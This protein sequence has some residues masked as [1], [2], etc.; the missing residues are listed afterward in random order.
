MPKLGQIKKA[1]DW[2]FEKDLAAADEWM[3]A[4]HDEI[5]LPIPDGVTEE[6]LKQKGEELGFTIQ[7]DS[8]HFNV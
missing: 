7:E 6:E 3:S 8:I 1:I 2:I 5:F 4:E